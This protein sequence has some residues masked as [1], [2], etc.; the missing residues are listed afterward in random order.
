MSIFF[1]ALD[2]RKPA[3]RLGHIRAERACQPFVAGDN[4]QQNVFLY[5]MC[6][7]GML[8]LAGFRIVNL[9]PRHQGLQHIGQHLGIRTRRQR[10]LLSFR[11]SFAAETTFMALVICRVFT[12]L[13]MRRRI[14]RMLGMNQLPVARTQLPVER[15]DLKARCSYSVLGTRYLLRHRFLLSATNCCFACL[16]T[17]VNCAFSASSRTFFSMIVRRSPALVASTYL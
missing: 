14:S 15:I 7:Q 2:S 10:A 1:P 13:R 4:N 5:P 8:W 12:T 3:R 9:R 11:R 17:S 6:Q 16:M